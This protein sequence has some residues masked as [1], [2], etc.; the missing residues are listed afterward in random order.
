LLGRS[1][2]AGRLPASQGQVDLDQ[3]FS[4]HLVA[5]RLVKL[6]QEPPTATGHERLFK[7]AKRSDDPGMAAVRIVPYIRILNQIKKAEINRFLAQRYPPSTLAQCQ[8]RVK[9]SRG[10]QILLALA[11]VRLLAALPR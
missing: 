3:Q 6:V 9:S 1:R 8:Y 2:F 4:P 5:G 7:M 11:K 10:A